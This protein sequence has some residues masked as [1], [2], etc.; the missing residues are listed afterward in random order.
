VSLRLRL[1]LA[2]T[3]AT[4]LVMVIAGLGLVALVAHDE[5]VALDRRLTNQAAVVGNPTTLGTSVAQR[6]LVVIEGRV[7]GG[8]ETRVTAGRDVLFASPTFPDLAAGPA[9]PGFSTADAGDAR[10]RL[11]TRNGVTRTPQGARIEVTMQFAAS[12]GPVDTAVASVRRRVILLGLGAIL[13]AGAIAWALAGVVLEPLRRLRGEAERVSETADLSVRVPLAGPSE[14]SEVAASLNTMLERLQEETARTAAA[15]EASR[16]FAA[17]AAHELRTPLTSMQ[18]NLDVLQRNPGLPPETRDAVVA[19]I[20]AQQ[21]RLLGVLEALRLLA[22]GDLGLQDLRTPVDLGDLAAAAVAQARTRAPDVAFGVRVTGDERDAVIEG[23]SEGLRV[24]LDNLLR[25]AATHGRP[26]TGAPVVQVEVA[27]APDAV[28][29][30]VD[31][32]GPGVPPAERA[33]VFERFVRGASPASGSGLGLAL[34]AQQAALHGGAVEVTQSPAGGAR[35]TVRL[36]ADRAAA[37]G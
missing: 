24:M 21:G 15:L 32:N 11:L 19:D 31:D 22:R 3:A 12:L 36:P 27:C 33:R 14:V 34:V 4:A 26:A 35:F 13:V 28:T 8:V 30:H 37:P 1:V 29:L 17:N 20:A 2:S 5:Q 18:T 7:E 25:N 16:A 23:W 6:R 10:W 9:T